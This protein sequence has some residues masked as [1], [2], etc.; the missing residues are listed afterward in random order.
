VFIVLAGKIS[1]QARRRLESELK[2]NIELFDIQRLIDEFTEYYP[3]VFFEGKTIDFLQEHIQRLET[4]HSLSKS[5]KNLSEY[6]V[7]PLVATIDSPIA[8]NT[9]FHGK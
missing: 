5:H 8:L 9:D 4:T 2:A 6:F 1:T 7:E 3:Q